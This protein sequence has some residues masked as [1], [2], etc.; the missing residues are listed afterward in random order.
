MISTKRSRKRSKLRVNP[1]YSNHIT[2]KNLRAQWRKQTPLRDLEVLNTR[3]FSPEDFLKPLELASFENLSISCASMY[4][5]ALSINVPSSETIL[6]VCH[7]EGEEKMEV[8]LNHELEQQF[9]SLPGK[10]RRNFKKLGIVIID[11]HT[12]PYYGNK[13]NRNVVSIKRKHGSS[14][15]YCYLTADLYSPKGCQTIALAQ[16]KP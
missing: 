3:D 9:L 1:N 5:R 11:F 16:R 7:N 6:D 2:Y 12:D 15:A 8:H 13:D 14:K 4:F 10:I